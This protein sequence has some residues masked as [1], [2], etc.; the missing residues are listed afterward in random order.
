MEE[1]FTFHLLVP[2]NKLGE[3]MSSSSPICLGPSTYPKFT[4]NSTGYFSS[5]EVLFRKAG[6]LT[7]TKISFFGRWRIPS[8]FKRPPHDDLI[9]APPP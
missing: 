6:S 4:G 9:I 1:V 8:S 7:N 2:K 3:M 5:L